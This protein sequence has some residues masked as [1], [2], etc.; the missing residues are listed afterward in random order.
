MELTTRT[1]LLLPLLGC[2]AFPCLQQL[3]CSG[4]ELS[5]PRRST[6]LVVAIWV[7]TQRECAECSLDLPTCSSW[8]H[9]QHVVRIQ[10]KLGG[11]CSCAGSRSTRLTSRL[12]GGWP[13]LLPALLVVRLASFFGRESLPFFQF[14]HC[15][16]TRKVRVSSLPLVFALVRRR[17]LPLCPS[18][19]LCVPLSLLFLRLLS[20]AS[21]I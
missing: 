3:L 17:L 16:D 7:V 21:C 11:T 19:S 4:T 10:R 13:S 6:R 1:S 9:P 15:S 14:S 20:L 5:E 12:T 18:V 2:G 8:R